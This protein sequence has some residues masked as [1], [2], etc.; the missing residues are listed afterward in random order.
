M[1]LAQIRPAFVPVPRGFAADVWARAS[2]RGAFA[3]ST[4]PRPGRAPSASNASPAASAPAAE[5]SAKASS[6]QTKASLLA[7]DL[8]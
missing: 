5:E 8:A 1:K 2:G 3:D 4:A 6:L 7:K